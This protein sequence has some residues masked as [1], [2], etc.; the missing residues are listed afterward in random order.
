VVE[1]EVEE[2]PSLEDARDAGLPAKEGGG[3]CVCV[4]GGGGGGEVGVGVWRGAFGG[5]GG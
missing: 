5:G 3:A 4:C 2:P 1:E